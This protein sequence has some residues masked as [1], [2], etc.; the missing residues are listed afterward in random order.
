MKILDPARRNIDNNAFA[1]WSNAY[2]HDEDRHP[3]TIT[4]VQPSV[5]PSHPYPRTVKELERADPK[6]VT[7]PHTV[8]PDCRW[9]ENE[10]SGSAGKYRQ[11]ETLFEKR[12]WI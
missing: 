6:K 3:H 4:T 12:L 7:H 11:T 2:G 1:F 8:F 5:M 10:N 9:G